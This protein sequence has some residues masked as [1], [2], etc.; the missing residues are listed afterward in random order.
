MIEWQQLDDWQKDWLRVD[1]SALKKRRD[2][3][4]RAPSR[5]RT[6]FTQ[7]LQVVRQGR[8]E[9]LKDY[10]DVFSNQVGLDSAIASTP[11]LDRLLELAEKHR[12][13]GAPDPRRWFEGLSLFD[14]AMA[15]ARI[16]FKDPLESVGRD[17]ESLLDYL[18]ETFFHDEYER[19]RVHAYHRPNE[20]FIVTE[21]DVSIGDS[22]IRPGKI[23]CVYP[24]DCRQIKGGGLAFMDERT[25]GAFSMWLKIGR[26]MFEGE[27][28]E[29]YTVNDRCGLIFV[30][31]SIAD[32]ESFAF[33][34]LE[35][36]LRDGAEELEKLA[37]TSSDAPV[38]PKNTRSSSLYRVAKMLVM[39]HEREF[40]F[41]FITF[42]DYF[43][44]KRSLTD[45]NHELYK[46]KQACDFA[47]PF[48]WPKEIYG[49]DW[50]QT[51]L[52]EEL[53]AWKV[54]Q[55]GWHV[56]GKIITET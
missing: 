32:L 16:E 6:L 35:T 8:R 52:R 22:L 27:V 55:L 28:T 4:R 12:E 44:S 5:D 23:H 10:A 53:R 47:L 41:Q 37:M 39:W 19:I 40:E 17:L 14:Q 49:I 7:S 54:D 3:L 43:T 24:L 56:N 25:K 9:L 2:F 50:S 26:K 11:H 38:D 31:P 1:V 33:L 30:V 29:T 42:H 15:I 51:R 48:L 34:L 45:A 20:Q 18:W 21:E 13:G 46:L 36:L